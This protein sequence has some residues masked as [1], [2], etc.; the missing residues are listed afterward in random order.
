MINK[1]KNKNK[2]ICISI[3]SYRDS[4]VYNTIHSLFKNASNY[5]NIFV[6][7]YLQD[8]I[9]TFCKSF[10]CIKNIYR[11]NFFIKTTSYKNAKGPLYARQ[12]IIKNMIQPSNKFKMF[13]YYLQLDSHMRF[14]PNWDIILINNYENLFPEKKIISYY[15]PGSFLEEKEKI[16]VLIEKTK[17]HNDRIDKYKTRFINSNIIRNYFSSEYIAAGFFF[18]EMKFILYEKKNYPMIEIPYLFQGEEML[19][20]YYFIKNNNFIIFSP[21]ENIAIHKYNRNNEHKIWNNIENWKELNNQAIEK[22]NKI[23]YN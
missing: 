2:K 12:Y 8:S 17:I 20:T 5:K 9:Y 4:D 19:L 15:P 18:T 11:Q 14:I 7:V 13:D 23:I 21:C 10:F 22:L 6:Y 3:C 1:N 16:P